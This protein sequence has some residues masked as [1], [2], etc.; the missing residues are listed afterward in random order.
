MKRK[1]CNAWKV[2]EELSSLK[3]KSV[4][5]LSS[6]IPALSVFYEKTSSWGGSCWVNELSIGMYGEEIDSGTQCMTI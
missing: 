3:S 6:V 4:L 5:T 1:K 2:F